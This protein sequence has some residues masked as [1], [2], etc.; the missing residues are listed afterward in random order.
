MLKKVG[1]TCEVGASPIPRDRPTRPTVLSGVQDGPL[2]SMK[3]LRRPLGGFFACPATDT[4][5]RHH[6]QR[7]ESSVRLS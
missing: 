7:L 2:G 5:G 1:R 6:H 3:I 4:S